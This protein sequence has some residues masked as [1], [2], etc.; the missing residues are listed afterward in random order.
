MG[1]TWQCGPAKPGPARPSLAEKATTAANTE[2]RGRQ[3]GLVYSAIK[4]REK[5][6]KKER[7]RGKERERR[8]RRLNWA[9]TFDPAV[10]E[11]GNAA[12]E[13]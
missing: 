11:E 5:E 12:G 9:G 10:K 1:L 7:K 2:E 4:K 8:R 3:L 6:R 13:G